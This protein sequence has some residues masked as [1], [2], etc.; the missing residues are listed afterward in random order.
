MPTQF[1][2]IYYLPDRRLVQAEGVSTVLNASL[3]AGIPHTHVC[4]GNAR[5]STCRVMILEGQE[6]CA[7]RTPAEQELAK[8]LGFDPGVRLACQ[9]AIAQTGRITLRRLALDADDVVNFYDQVN[10]RVVPQ[11]MGHEQRLAILFA[12]IRGFTAFSEGLP[13][14]DVIYVLNRYF[15]RMAQVIKRYGGTINVYM[16]DGLM[17]LFGIDQADH[18]AARAVQA[19]LAMLEAVEALNPSFELL[20]Q[21]RLRIGIGIHCGETVIGS[22]GDP[23]YPK[24]TA[25]GDA[26]NL[27]SRIE[28]ANKALGTS[29]LISEVVYQ[30]LQ[31]QVCVRQGHCVQVPGKSGEYMLYEVESL[32]PIAPLEVVPERSQAVGRDRPANGC[33]RWWQ[34]LWRNLQTIFGG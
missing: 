23:S 29:L 7:P 16:G 10:G 20:Y 22:I 6:Y 32:T 13:P 28:A 25:I 2:Q 21:Q 8:K 4:G 15:Q 26:V 11:M 30:E 24:M 17:A 5:C 18:V 9:T 33:W 12:D 14:Y 1:M 34:T 3:E 19:G 27:A 31:G